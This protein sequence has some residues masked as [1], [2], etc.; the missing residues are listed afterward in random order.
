MVSKR[1]DLSDKRPALLAWLQGKMPQAWNLTISNLE[2]SGGGFSNETFFFNATWEEGDEKKSERM[3]LRCPPTGFPVFPDYDLSKQF[4]IMKTLG[5]TD[6]P[7]PKMY[8][9]EQGKEVLGVP[10]YVMKFTEGVVAPEYPP[11]HSFG[12]LYDATPE[13]REKIWWGGVEAMAKIHKLDWESMGLHFLGPTVRGTNAVDREL[14]YY[15][16]F[17]NWAREGEPQPIL[18]AALKWLRENKVAPKHVGLC[19]GDCRLP[20][21][22]LGPERDIAAVVDWEMASLSDPESDLAWFLFMDW[23]HC[24]GYGIPRLQGFP[25]R[26]ETIKRYEELTGRKVENLFYYEVLAAFKFGV[27]LLKVFKN[28]RQMGVAL[29]AD[30]AELNNVCT[31]RLAGLLN[32]EPPGERKK[33]ETTRIEDITVTAQFHLTGPGGGDWYVLCDKGKATRHEGTAETP[34][35]TMAASAQDWAAIQRGE[36]DRITAWTSGKL[37]IDGDMALLLQLEDV[38]AKLR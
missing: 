5:S 10:F 2:R 13:Q 6:V 24:D 29:P 14:D 38:I 32:L 17:L 35:V 18:E 25:D 26:E 30:D 21:L 1:I 8:W 31:Q 36:M 4:R 3:V 23:Q 22:I 11:Y 19:W 16:H 34:N 33:R 20:N 28:F 9:I 37:K 7:V 12:L 27:I 15:E